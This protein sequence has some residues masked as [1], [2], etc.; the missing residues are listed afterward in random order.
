MCKEKLKIEIEN[1]YL[2][3]WE[4]HV[5]NKWV[6]NTT[7]SALPINQSER[8]TVHVNLVIVCPYS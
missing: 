1:N 5:A 6:T 4:K 8:V 7:C 3:L 2:K